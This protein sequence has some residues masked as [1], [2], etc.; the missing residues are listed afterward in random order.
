L[1]LDAENLPTV[2]VMEF[3]D[4]IALQD[5]GSFMA[6]YSSTFRSDDPS[7]FLLPVL[8]R[9]R[10]IH[11]RDIPGVLVEGNVGDPILEH[12]TD[13]FVMPAAVLLIIYDSGKP[14][15]EADRTRRVRVCST[16]LLPSRRCVDML[17]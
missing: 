1:L 12:V 2:A 8:V 13:F 15:V 17:L 3:N 6:S 14:H 11:P 9:A 5:E 16:F 7:T 4:S 10:T